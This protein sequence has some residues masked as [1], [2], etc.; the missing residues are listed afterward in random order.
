MPC[1]KCLACRIRRRSIWSIRMLHEITTANEACFI[2][3]TYSNENLPLRGSDTRGILVKSDLQNFFKRLRKAGHEFR[4][5]ACGEY[6]DAGGRPH[7]HAILFG[8]TLSK[9]ELEKHWQL[10]LCDSGTATEASVKYVAGYV[11]KKLG[12]TDYEHSNRPA[13]FQVSSQG[14]GMDWAKENM[15]ETLLEGSLKFHGA[16]LPIPRIYLSWY[17]EIFP[18]AVDGFSARQQYAADLALTEL[19]LELAP[20]CGGKSWKQLDETEKANV[21]IQLH[22]RGEQMDANLRAAASMRENKL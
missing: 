19:I 9:E 17:E 13:P 6:G 10:G 7:Y 11:S 18:E 12:L 3:L 5:Y 1:G 2:T 14:I 21:L 16:S 22:K 20:Q 4:Y 15:I 8:V